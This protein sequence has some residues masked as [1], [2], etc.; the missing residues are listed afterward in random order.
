[1]K[2]KALAI[3]CVLLFVAAAM[4]PAR[5]QAGFLV[6]TW[7]GN[8]P[9]WNRVLGVSGIR[10]GCSDAPSSCI[11]YVEQMA[12]SQHVSSVFLGILL[13]PANLATNAATFGNLALSHPNLAEV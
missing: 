13:K 10:I 5:P 3:G 2:R 7:G 1:M 6:I 12:A 9:E 11:Q 4:T 8:S